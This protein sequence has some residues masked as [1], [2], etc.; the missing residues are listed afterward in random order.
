VGNPGE[1]TIKE[2]AEKVLRG[3]PDSRSK[4]VYQPL[5][6]DDPRQRQPDITFAGELLGWEPKV[7]LDEG[8]KRTIAWFRAQQKPG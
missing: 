4:L 3:I 1:F 2:L 5:P 7:P 6:C 8:L